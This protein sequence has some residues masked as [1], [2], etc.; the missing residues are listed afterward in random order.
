MFE[1]DPVFALEPD[2]ED[3]ELGD[4]QED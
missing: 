2:E 1:G 4:E 3:R